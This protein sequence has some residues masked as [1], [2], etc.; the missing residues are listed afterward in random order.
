MYNTNKEMK[1]QNNSQEQPEKKAPPSIKMLDQGT[2]GCVFRPGITCSGMIDQ[3]K[4]NITKIQKKQE[5]SKN[6]AEIGRKIMKIPNYKHNYAPITETCN[7]DVGLIED[8]ELQKCEFIEKQTKLGEPLNYEINQLPFVGKNT[9]SEYHINLMEK[10]RDIPNFARKFITNY[11]ILVDGYSKMAEIGIIHFDTKENNIMCKDQSGRPVIIDYGMSFDINTL[12]PT[13]E[14]IMKSFFVY[15]PEYPVWCIEI[16]MISYM[17]HNIGP[18]IDNIEE[19]LAIPLSKETIEPCIKDYIDKSRVMRLLSDSEKEDYKKKLTEYYSTQISAVGLGATKWKKIYEDAIKTYKSWDIYALSVCYLQIYADLG[20]DAYAKEVPF[21]N[22]FKEL[23]KKIITSLPSDRV[24]GK[25]L[26][27][28]M[29]TTLS[30]VSKEEVVKLQEYLIN[31][32]G[33]KEIIE[34]RRKLVSE[35]KLKTEQ[36]KQDI[37]HRRKKR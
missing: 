3:S 34:T 12:I 11:K 18:K 13:D 35:S 31:D 17:L 28:E 27:K 32:I 7:V 2:Y 30:V 20:L 4:T 25:D 22:N 15:A 1:P 5:T 37:I 29:T 8:G 19:V 36:E 6:E 14:S 33:N 10:M 23:L 9:L 24:I 26:L 16:H 21:L